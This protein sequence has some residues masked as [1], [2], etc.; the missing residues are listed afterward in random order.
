MG[1]QPLL[2]II[3]HKG[4]HLYY[5]PVWPCNVLTSELTSFN[6]FPYT[7]PIPRPHPSTTFISLRIEPQ[8]FST[9]ANLDCVYSVHS[10]CFS[11]RSAHCFPTEAFKWSFPFQF[12]CY[13]ASFHLA[14]RLNDSPLIHK[15]ALEQS[16]AA[17]LGLLLATTAWR[18]FLIFNPQLPDFQCDLDLE[19]QPFHP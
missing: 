8:P 9:Q 12:L 5:F 16:D 11:F 7:L 13:S 14:L 3:A 6:T 18:L 17:F 2:E 4:L 19:P 1:L 15:P 10:Y